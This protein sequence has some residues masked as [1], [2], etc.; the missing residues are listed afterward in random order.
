MV[1]SDAQQ[2]LEKKIALVDAWIGRI[3]E[4]VVGEDVTP[5]TLKDVLK[6]YGADL[7]PR[8]ELGALSAYSNLGKAPG[9][10]AVWGEAKIK[11]YK[12]WLKGVYIPEYERQIGRELPTLYDR[13]TKTYDNVKHSGMLQF[14]GELTAYAAGKKSFADYKRIT[15]NRVRKGRKWRNEGIR[16]HSDNAPIVPEFP[17]AAWGYLKAENK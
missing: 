14:L 7:E 8:P 5:E 1:E 10:V 9:L 17:V 3:S 13:K 12:Q 2:E 16:E 15:E 4:G 6:N 11:A